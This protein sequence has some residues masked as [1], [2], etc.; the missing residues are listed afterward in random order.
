MREIDLIVVHCSATREDVDFTEQDL[1]RCHRRRGFNGTGYHFYVRKSGEVVPT[2]PVERI[3]AHAKGYNAHSVGVCYEGGLD[4][5]GKPKDTR[6]ECQKKALQVLL[7]ALA[8][9]YPGSRICGH[10]DLS[11]DRNGD[12]V[13]GPEEWMKACPCYEVKE[14]V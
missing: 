11:P 12:G 10:R 3:G 14:E 6:T 13:I 4:K 1:E 7:A 5:R 2:R 8:V 9:K